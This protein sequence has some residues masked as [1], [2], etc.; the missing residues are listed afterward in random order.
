MNNTP[1]PSPEINFY[2]DSCPQGYGGTFQSHFF[3]G[4]FPEEWQKYNICV[5]ELYPIL[6]ALQLYASS[7]A[8]QHIIIF[9]DNIA[10]VQ[11]LTHKTTKHKQM[12]I[13][14]R[15]MILHCLEHNIQ[16]T[17]KHIRGK[18]NILADA[19]SRSSHTIDLLQ[20]MNMDQ[21]PTPIPDRLKPTAYKI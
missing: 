13:L 11:V 8:N 16:F 3:F 5:L 9:S 2:T 14:L 1:V 19:L 12:L 4:K 15:H 18:N 10:V 7:I 17:A 6:L 21:H 20:I